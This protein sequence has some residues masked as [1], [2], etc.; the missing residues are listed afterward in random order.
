M[1]L[2]EKGQ[3]RALQS[4]GGALLSADASAEAGLQELERFRLHERLLP[5][6]VLFGMEKSWVHAL[7]DHAAALREQAG[8]M[9]IV[10]GA[11]EV[12]EVIELVGGAAQLVHAVGELADA[13]GGA[14]GVVGEVVDGLS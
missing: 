10:D 2:A 5:Y 8:G 3:L 12:L 9:D 7:G 6:A 4:V 14:V 1:D 13:A 11:F